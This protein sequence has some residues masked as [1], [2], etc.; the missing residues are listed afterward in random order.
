MDTFMDKLAHKLTAQEMIKANSA[1]DAE[2][3][4]RLKSQIKEYREILDRLQAMVDDSVVKLENGAARIENAKA[5]ESEINRLV[6]ESIAKMDTLANSLDETKADIAVTKACVRETK[7]NLEATK[8]DIE[9]TKA[10]IEEAKAGLEET[11]L[12]F[13]DSKA[14]IEE[15][16]VINEELKN[17]LFEK[18]KELDDNVHKECV[19]VYRNVQA[20]VVEENNKQ[21]ENHTFTINEMKKKQGTILNVSVLAL[22]FAAGSLIFQVLLYLHII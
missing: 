17:T 21:S 11:R 5:D 6:A 7:T 22:L 9:E 20:V 3:M 15:S 1:A 12:G 2:E 10:G 4:N 13:A 19:K 16:K 18:V 14:V 8:A